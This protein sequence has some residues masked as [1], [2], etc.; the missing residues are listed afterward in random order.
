[1]KRPCRNG[2]QTSII[3]K[4]VPSNTANTSNYNE[5]KNL[6]YLL[7][8]VLIAS[9]STESG[10]YYIDAIN[11][12]DNDSGNS[13]KSAWKSLSKVNKTTFQPGIKYCLKLF[14]NGMEW[15]AGNKRKWFWTG[16]YSN[17]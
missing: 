4:G 3:K 1:M 12:D 10:I 9:C 17:K 5:M 2:S 16:F 13:P 7:L 11:G 8:L 6:L 15:T 14:A